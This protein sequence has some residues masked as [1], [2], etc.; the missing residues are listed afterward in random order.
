MKNIL[1]AISL[2]SV[3]VFACFFTF[4][5][6]GFTK[7][8]AINIS[9]VMVAFFVAIHQAIEKHENRSFKS[10]QRRIITID[11]YGYPWYLMVIYGITLTWAISSAGALTS[12]VIG[13]A[14]GFQ[15]EQSIKVS[16]LYMF[17]FTQSGLYFT[18]RWVGIKSLG[19]GI[20]SVITIGLVH[21]IIEN[22]LNWSFA[23][24]RAFSIFF[25]EIERSVWLLIMMMVGGWVIRVPLLIFGYW[26]GRRIRRVSYLRFLMKLIPDESKNAI[27]DLAFEEACILLAPSR[28]NRSNTLDKSV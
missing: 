10:K 19:C 26:R 21:S 1:I 27:I 12:G 18:G 16:L 15:I 4:S 17:L 24:D 23:S 13:A 9:G 28:A 6:L 5:L 20:W 3:L 25:G 14:L 22:F 7:E 2:A 8:N 11:H